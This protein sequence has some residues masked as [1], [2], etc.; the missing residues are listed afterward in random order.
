[1]KPFDAKSHAENDGRA[2]LACL[3][4]LHANGIEAEENCVDQ[5]DWDILVKDPK[6][7]S[8]FIEVEVKNIWKA[9][10]WPTYWREVNVLDRKGIHMEINV[11]LMLFRDDL[12]RALMVPGEA[13]IESPRGLVKNKF[14][15]EGEWMFKVP[16]AL[17]R[18]V[19]L[20]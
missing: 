18:E 13:I 3:A 5:Y 8:Q 10:P 1:M 9:G 11:T 12:K 20:E 16:F 4:W 6:R 17:C 2:K 15:P 14:V 19:S 7:G